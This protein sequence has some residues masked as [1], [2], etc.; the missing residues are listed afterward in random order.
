MRP[1]RAFL[2][3]CAEDGRWT[4]NSFRDLEPLVAAWKEIHAS[5]PIGA[6]IHVGFW[7]PDTAAIGAIVVRFPG[8]LLLSESAVHAMPGSLSVSALPVAEVEG[9]GYRLALSGFGYDIVD[10]TVASKLTVEPISA[11][12]KMEASLPDTSDS[13]ASEP[14]GWVAELE[15]LDTDLAA[16][17]RQTN[18]WDEVSYQLHEKGLEVNFRQRVGL[19]RFILLTGVQPRADNMLDNIRSCP[20]WFVALRLNQLRLTVRQANVFRAHNL[21]TVKDLADMGTNGLLKLPQMGRKSVNELAVALYQALL[22]G[23]PHRWEEISTQGK[24][25]LTVGRP[26]SDRLTVVAPEGEARFGTFRSELVDTAQKFSPL[27]RGILA[28]RMGFKCRRMTLQEIAADLGKTRE[29]VRQI[30]AKICDKIRHAPLWASLECRLCELL[31]HRTSPLLLDGLPALDPWFEGLDVLAGPLEFA[32]DHFLDERLKIIEF[33]STRY[34]SRLAQADWDYELRAAKRMLEASVPD[35]LAEDDARHLIESLLVGPGEELRGELWTQASEYARFTDDELGI[36]RLVSYGRSGEAIVHAILMESLVPLHY[37]EIQRRTSKYVDPPL[38]TRRTHSAASNIGILYS[39]GTYGLLRHCLLNKKELALVCVEVEDL[40]SAE[41]LD[42]QW[43][44]TELCD[45][46]LERGLDF[47]GRLTEYIVNIALGESEYF[48]SLGRL[49]WGLKDSWRAGTSSRIDVRQA[50]IA[51]LEREGHPL[52]TKEIRSRLEEERGLS[53]HF[54]IFPVHPLVRV[55]PSEWGLVD[56]DIQV[57]EDKLRLLAEA[58][59][60]RL[61]SLSHGVHMSEVRWELEQQI[62]MPII[63]D[64]D[65]QW[66]MTSIKEL[67]VRVDRGQYFFLSEWGSSRRLTIGEAVNAALEGQVDDRGMS[68]EDICE[69]TTSILLRPCSRG[70]VSGSLQ[71]ANVVF[72]PDTGLWRRSRDDDAVP[73]EE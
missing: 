63:A 33:D 58:L 2:S 9:L 53:G 7:R 34:V 69:R 4:T 27:Q 48:V 46:L 29:R 30:E 11:G 73:D 57:S 12:T 43:H 21:S 59:H 51:L 18:I 67:G 72:D 71:S 36:R 17:V 55:G 68:L 5:G 23:S 6:A 10:P 24:A 25:N 26:V 42:R 35:R 64:F 22:D 31:E 15:K 52:T 47:E 32:F 20:P 1:L 66:L 49:V 3:F 41:S 19:A 28:A 44:C 14:S 61:E 65:P 16:E 13:L 50:V 60:S 8:V 54:Q 45:A 56:R 70:A 39:R 62:G 37:S 40:V 38:E